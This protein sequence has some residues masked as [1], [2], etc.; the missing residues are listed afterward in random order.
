MANTLRALREQLEILQTWMNKVIRE[1]GVL[2]SNKKQMLKTVVFKG[3]DHPRT[4][5]VLE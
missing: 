1:I 3:T 5:G 4:V 2:R